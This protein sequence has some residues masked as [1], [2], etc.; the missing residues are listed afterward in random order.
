M[1]YVYFSP[2]PSELSVGDCVIRAISKLT[3]LTWEQVYIELM[4]LGFMMCDMPS[5]NRV[6]DEFLQLYSQRNM[7]NYGNMRGYSGASKETMIHDLKS[8]LDETKAADVKQAISN[9]I[10]LMEK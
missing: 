9:C 8:M 7:G 4:V 6:W 10:S 3:N 5:A 2:N 1:S